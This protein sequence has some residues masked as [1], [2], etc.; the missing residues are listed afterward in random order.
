MFQS[1]TPQNVI[2]GANAATDNDGYTLVTTAQ[3]CD[4]LNDALTDLWLWAKRC[5]RDAFTK[6]TS[7]FSI[8]SGSNTVSMTAASPGLALT[9]WGTPR[10]VDVQV[11]GGSSMINWKKLRLWNFTTRD[12]VYRLCYRFIGETLWIYPADQAAQ[13][14][15]RVWYLSNAPVV[16]S[17]ALSTAFSIPEG[18]KDFLI[19]TLAAK[20]RIRLDD[21]PAPHLAIAGAT[22][23]ATEANLAQ[24]K[25]DQGS[26]ADVS[27]ETYPDA[28]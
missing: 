28:Y 2:D 10:G 4:W 21:D 24:A 12:R 26:I 23:L 13:Y 14:P 16:S 25:G 15:L 20:I 9:D 11:G 22:R 18:A 17:S 8:S 6:V 1:L 27:D 3:L 7:A 5:N 19:Q